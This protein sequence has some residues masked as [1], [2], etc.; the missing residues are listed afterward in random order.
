M[1]KLFLPAVA[2]LS[3]LALA[4]WPPHVLSHETLT[5]TVL[6]DREIVRILDKHCVVCHVENGPSFPL[7]TYEETWLRGRPIR[8]AVL[9]RHMPPWAAV[10]GYGQF[11]NENVL[12]LREMQFVI[13]WVE[14]LGPR[15]AGTVFLN[16]LDPRAVAK[17]PVQAHADFGT[18]ELGPP[19]L[20]RRVSTERAV[21]DLGLTAER[22]IRALEYM[23]ADRRALRSAVFTVQET[24]QWLGSWTPWWGFAKLPPG[25]MY[26]LP[27]GSHMVAELSYLDGKPHPSDNGSVGLYF[28]D[29]PA[30]KPASDLV[31]EAKGDQRLRAQT[32]LTADTHVLALRPEITTGMTSLEVSARRPDGGT[33]VLLFA[34]DFSRDWPTPY[35]FKEPVLLRRGTELVVTAYSNTSAG[36]GVRLIVSRY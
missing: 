17:P 33:D 16:V 6:F 5:T 13:S 10:Q 34:K 2:F 30:A 26:R 3:A 25:V 19:N 36:A 18:W 14:G 32:R 4:V 1:K 28:A 8:A 27:A 21:I 12:T 29:E 35:I 7:S 11:A 31:L 22:R 24:G 20:T 23:P 15:N 9:A